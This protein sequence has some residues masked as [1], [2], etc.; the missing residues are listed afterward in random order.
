MGKDTFLDEFGGVAG[1]PPK[2]TPKI[3]Q[4]PASRADDDDFDDDLEDDEEEDFED[5]EDF[6]DAYDDD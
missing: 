5:D 2:P 4:P 3:V 6:D 1:R